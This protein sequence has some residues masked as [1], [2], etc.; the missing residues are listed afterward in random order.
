MPQMWGE[1]GD[2]RMSLGWGNVFGWI[3]DR[4]PSKKEGILNEINKINKRRNELQ[5]KWLTASPIDRDVSEYTNLGRML[6]ELE[7]R[8]KTIKA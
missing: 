1:I 8:L 5:D 7:E 6:A 3:F 2:K 4:L